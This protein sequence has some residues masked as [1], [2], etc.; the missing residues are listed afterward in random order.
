MSNHQLNQLDP[1]GLQITTTETTSDE[2][3][4]VEGSEI[5]W[6]EVQPKTGTTFN[7]DVNTHRWT[8]LNIYSESDIIKYGINKS[9]GGLSDCM[10]LNDVYTAY[11]SGG[12][13]CGSIASSGFRTAIHPNAKITIPITGGT[14]TLSGLTSLDLYTAFIYQNDSTTSDGSG[15]CATWLVD[16][17]SSE[18]KP[19]STFEAG[20]GY[21]YDI[22]NNPS[23]DTNGQYRSGLMYLFNKEIYFSGNTGTTWDTGWSGASRYTFGNSPLA[24]FEGETKNKS[25]GVLH[26]DSGLI[27]LYNQEI[28]SLFNTSVATGGTIT[29]GL[30]FPTSECN[31]I[32]RDKD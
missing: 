3:Y 8:D 16:S 7:T 4:L 27:T 12:M 18:S 1:G 23:S 9:D 19:E 10:G 21:A 6:V 11:N 17:L 26:V 14:G 28:V 29:S 5:S 31:A 30:T 13:I 25:V 24:I 15:P 22:Q 20:L 2:F 32:I